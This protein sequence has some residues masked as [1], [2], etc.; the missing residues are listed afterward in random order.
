MLERKNID[1]VF[2]ENLKDLEVYPNKRVWNSIEG[3]LNGNISRPA[4]ALWKKLSGVAVM[5]VALVTTGLLYF[6]NEKVVPVNSQ[7]IESDATSIDRTVETPLS[8]VFIN[9]GTELTDNTKNKVR[10]SEK[11]IFEIRFQK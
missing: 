7:V 1:R 11:P 9:Q 10:K 2:Q 6:N 5:L 4:V 3:R 8:P